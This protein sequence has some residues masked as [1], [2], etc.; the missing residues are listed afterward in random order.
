MP[1]PPI[2]PACSVYR[3]RQANGANGMSDV[4]GKVA[5]AAMSECGQRA[6]FNG[7]TGMSDMAG[8]AAQVAIE[9]SGRLPRY[10]ADQL[11]TINYRSP[12]TSSD[13]NSSFNL[14]PV[15]AIFRASYERTFLPRPSLFFNSGHCSSKAKILSRFQS[16][17]SSLPRTWRN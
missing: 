8:K 16:S 12:L 9:R 14:L 13:L 11:L 5:R 3:R 17:H 2:T 10:N 7:A 15:S 4:E 1:S 6:N